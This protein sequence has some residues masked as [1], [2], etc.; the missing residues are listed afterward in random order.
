MGS[1]TWTWYFCSSGQFLLWYPPSGTAG[2]ICA[3]GWS[4]SLW[5]DLPPSTFCGRSCCSSAAPAISHHGWSCWNSWG[6]WCLPASPS[7]D[8][9]GKL[10]IGHDIL[11]LWLWVSIMTHLAEVFKFQHRWT[12]SG[13]Y[14][15]SQHGW[16]AGRVIASRSLQIVVVVV[17][18]VADNGHEVGYL[19]RLLIMGSNIILAS[20]APPFETSARSVNFAILSD[21]G[22]RILEICEIEQV[23][24]CSFRCLHVN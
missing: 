10:L 8:K 12:W 16:P 21:W 24:F 19:L 7:S 5:R 4:C 2:N 6:T 9:L 14:I 11:F 13:V 1:Y 23:D 18:F 3:S 22:Y 17:L 15:C 20:C